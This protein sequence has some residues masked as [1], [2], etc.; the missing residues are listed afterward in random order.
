M[1][2]LFYVL[3]IA[4]VLLGACNNN[5]PKENDHENHG[6]TEMKNENAGQDHH[7]G[8]SETNMML[9]NGK[10]WKANP[11]T[12]TGIDN[13]Q[14]IVRNGMNGKTDM[15][16]LHEPL[17]QAF[18]TIFDKCTMTGESHNQLHNFLLPMKADLEKFKA[19]T[20]S[21]ESLQEMQ[22]YL[23]TFKNYFE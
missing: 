18:K 11:E 4:L 10:K 21:T 9:D 8:E 15:S 14:K 19:G 17:Q 13:M 1:K 7:H 16:K 2:K 23:L 12:L 20:I 5:S 6:M 3:P 22:A